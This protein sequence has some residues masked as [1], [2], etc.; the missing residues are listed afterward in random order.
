MQ[1]LTFSGIAEYIHQ[2]NHETCYLSLACEPGW[3]ATP[4]GSYCANAQDHAIADNDGLHISLPGVIVNGRVFRTR[5]VA[6]QAI[7]RMFH[8]YGTSR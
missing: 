8:R 6:H 2:A 7:L 3:S 5:T 4:T 1:I